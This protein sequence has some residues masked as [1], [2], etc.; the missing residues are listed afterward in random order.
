MHLNKFSEII[1][2]KYI[3]DLYDQNDKYILF[4]ANLT[5]IQGILTTTM[6]IWFAFNTKYNCIFI[7]FEFEVEKTI[8][9]NQ[10]TFT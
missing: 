8:M 5:L 10:D 9:P 6:N 3:Y 1:D 2:A 4:A 7:L